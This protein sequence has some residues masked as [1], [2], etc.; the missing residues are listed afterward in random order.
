M[1]AHLKIQAS[2]SGT[3]PKLRQ[4]NA[5][6]DASRTVKQMSSPEPMSLAKI[7]VCKRCQCS[8]RMGQGQPDPRPNGLGR[9]NK[10]LAE[11]VARTA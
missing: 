9:C 4:T 5:E 11:K 1:T 2:I 3:A 6:Y 8:F 7:Y 10:C